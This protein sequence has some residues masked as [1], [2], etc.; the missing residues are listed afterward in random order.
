MVKRNK[1]ESLIKGGSTEED[2]INFIWNVFSVLDSGHIT[3][4]YGLG[5]LNDR[6]L[7]SHGSGGW[8][9]EVRAPAWL[10]SG[11]ACLPGL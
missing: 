7:F 8:Q 1:K 11:A 6:S 10:G 2:V 3:K 4:S 9:S 5:G